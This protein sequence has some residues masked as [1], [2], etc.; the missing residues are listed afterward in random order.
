LGVGSGTLI[1]SNVQVYSNTAQWGGGI[2]VGPNAEVSGTSVEVY[3]N[4]ASI[5]GG[6]LRLFGGRATFS[7]SNIRSNSA[8]VGG[9]VYG[10]LETAFAPALNLPSSADVYGNQA[11]TGSGLGGGVYMK[12]GSVTMTDCSDVYSNS[13]VEGGGLYLL[14]STLMVSGACS[15][16][17]SN[18]STGNGGGIYAI[19]AS[20]VT[21]E[22]QVEVLYNNAGTGG[23]G[24]GGGAYLDA[25][26]LYSLR[27]NVYYD[28]AHDYGGGI[29]ATNG[30]TVAME[31]GGFTCLGPRCSQLS[32]NTA[33]GAYGGGLYAS[34]G[35]V[36][37]SNVFVENNVALL[38]GGIYAVTSATVYAYN[39]LIAR[40]NATSSA[41]DGVRLNS[42]T[43]TASGVTLAYNDAGGA[44]PATPSTWPPA[45]FPWDAPSSG[46]T[47]PAST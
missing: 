28:T 24:S 15:E 36:Q 30:S 40:N 25:S 20:T 12:Q 2:W 5:Y 9:G 19:Q 11:L 10:S 4:T 31:L 6:G 7:N 18:T 32:H 23:S 29:Y 37:L 35:S 34:G 8:P 27:S 3:S 38:G 42:A 26:S 13:A 33:T 17:D 47:R 39:S 14:G 1:L 22:D 16:V 21:I 44:S 43:M 46:A 45:R 41:G